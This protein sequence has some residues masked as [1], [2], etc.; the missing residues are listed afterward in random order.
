MLKFDTMVLRFFMKVLKFK[1][2]LKAYLCQKSNPSKDSDLWVSALYY[3][4]QVYDDN[5]DDNGD[6]QWHGQNDNIDHYDD[7]HN[8]L[9]QCDHINL[10]SRRW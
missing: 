7:E 4:L 5:G 10:V 3:K 8:D 2:E 6:H 9:C 1:G